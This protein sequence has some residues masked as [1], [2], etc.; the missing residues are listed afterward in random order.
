MA[1]ALAVALSGSGTPATAAPAV[2]PASCAEVRPGTFG[3]APAGPLQGGDCRRLTVPKGGYH[4]IEVVDAQ[5][6][7]RGFTVY[8]AAGAQVCRTANCNL[9]SAGM[10]T[11]VAAAIAVPFATVLIPFDAAGCEA[12]SDQGFGAD[13]YRGSVTQAGE[14]DCLEL[15]GG[16]GLYQAALPGRPS[17]ENWQ[18]LRMI[19]PA[20][21]LN[22]SNGHLMSGDGCKVAVGGPIRMLVSTQGNQVSDDY[23]VAVQRMTA[24]TGC[25]EL[26]AGKATFD[27][28]ADRFVSCFTVPAGHAAREIFALDRLAGDTVASLRIFRPDGVAACGDS[29]G[30][31]GRL[32]GC[33]LSDSGAYTVL[34]HAMYANGTF[35]LKRMD[36]TGANCQKAVS[37]A[38]GGAPSTGLLDEPGEVHCYHTGG[39]SWVRVHAA[40]NAPYVR[41]FDAD[42]EFQVCW[43]YSCL[44][45]ASYVF[46]TSYDDVDYKV[47]TW[48][49]GPSLG[50]AS[51]CV[52]SSE[53]IAYGFAPVTGTLTPADRAWCRVVTSRPGDEFLVEA[54]G[55]AG[56]APL[57][58]VLSPS[59]AVEACDG[60]GGGYYLCVPRY[61]TGQTTGTS[62]IALVATGDTAP[63]TYSAEATCR[64]PLCGGE[65]YSLYPVTQINVTAGRK[66]TIS[67]TGSALNLGDTVRLTRSGHASINAVVR[68]VS[69]NRR[70]MTAEV[71]LTKAAAGKWNVAVT[72]ASSASRTAL[73]NNLVN[74]APT[75]KLGVRSKP[76]VTGKAAVG[77]TVRANAGTWNPAPSS[78]RYQWTANGVAI[79]GA[80]GSAYPIPASMRGKRI[81][82][83]VTARASGYL[84]TSVASAAVTV[85]YGVAPKVTK[86]PKITGTVKAGKTVKVTVGAWSPKATSYRYEWRLNG[87]VIK[88]ATASSLKIKKAWKGK[89]LTVVVIAK[90]A[91]HYDGRATSAAV[92][93]K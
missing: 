42:G 66:A 75:P 28:T 10:Y 79:K 85:G 74:V 8:D 3:A 86:K 58:Y 19:S 62:V 88:G 17:A 2:D 71:D 61:A 35:Q 45:N 53:S 82:V 64:T 56:L 47:D 73:L 87:K 20:A 29:G 18:Y 40:V 48:G 25:A 26:P 84:D 80:T 24:P 76:A 16:A 63:I 52:R 93:V 27:F 23:A 91:G 90:R 14:I 49:I 69:A 51:D 32:F 67:L 31:T 59:G 68:S 21:P 72:S 92:K 12:V 5:N 89:K 22:C 81:A 44:I 46:V 11:L 37:T 83:I 43:D 1:V 60:Q 55:A 41:Y 39:P 30:S 57:P 6:V 70:A 65:T 54:Q 36:A 15:P 34:V 7:S 38:F 77:L 50:S 33:A 4:L 13:A 78:V 9:P